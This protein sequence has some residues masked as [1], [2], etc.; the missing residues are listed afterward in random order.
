MKKRIA[1]ILS[2]IFVI[3]AFVASLLFVFTGDI[4]EQSEE[5]ISLTGTWK[6]IS[7]FNN[8]IP[9]LID[10]E[11]MVFNDTTALN[12]KEDLTAPYVSSKYEINN[13][14]LELS[15]ISR[16]YQI[17]KITDNILRL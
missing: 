14:V 11:F 17:E 15:D 8:D 1:I 12:Y 7:Y 10:N 6:V 13:K 2:C 9:T 16:T 5:S 4:A 3:T